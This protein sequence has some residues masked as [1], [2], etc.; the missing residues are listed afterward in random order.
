MWYNKKH[1]RRGTLWEERF[2]S[3]LIEDSEDALRTMAAYIDLNPVRAGIVDDPKDYRWCG[4]TEAMGGDQRARR[5]IQQLLAEQFGV[6]LS[7]RDAAGLYRCWLFEGGQR[8]E[9]REGRTIRKGRYPRT[10][11]AS[12]GRGRS[13]EAQGVASLPGALFHSRRGDWKPRIRRRIRRRI[14]RVTSRSVWPAL[15]DRCPADALRRLERD[16]QPARSARR[17][18]PAS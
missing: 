4:Y 12:L 18:H 8:S 1:G 3:V 9:D 16:V 14:L 5:S 11:R 13:L 17:C 10:R 2:G 7:W 15:K 6:E